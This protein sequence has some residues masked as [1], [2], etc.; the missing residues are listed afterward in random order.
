[1]IFLMQCLNKYQHRQSSG[2]VNLWCLTSL[3]I[4]VICLLFFCVTSF[5]YNQP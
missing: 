5:L 1:L 2:P 4:W 3:A